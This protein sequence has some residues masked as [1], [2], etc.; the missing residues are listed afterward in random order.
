MVARAHALSIRLDRFWHAKGPFR[1]STSST[2]AYY[3]YYVKFWTFSF[4]TTTPVDRLN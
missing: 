3:E 2:I 4:A 1:S